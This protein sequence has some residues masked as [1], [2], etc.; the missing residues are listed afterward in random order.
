M[1]AVADGHN[2]REASEAAIRGIDAE[3]SALLDR[4]PS[5]AVAEAFAVAMRAVRGAL[6]EVGDP[7]S[8][9]ATAL[10]VAVGNEGVACHAGVGDTACLIA[11]RTRT[12]MFVGVDGFIDARSR[13]APSVR[14][15][16][17]RTGTAVVLATDGLTDFLGPGGPR[18]V[19]GAL[20][21]RPADDAR[22]LVGLA[23]D[24]GA[25]DNIAVALWKS[26]PSSAGGRPSQ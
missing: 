25:G 13:P 14:R 8:G 16:A 7:R 2:G 15:V 5:L 4:K 6:A 10:S 24:G 17:V 1:L 26:R 12:R 3:A 22:R 18:L 9:S 20:R 23:F 21:G 19:R 11:R